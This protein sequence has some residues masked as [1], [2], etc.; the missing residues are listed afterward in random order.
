VVHVEHE[1][2][3]LVIVDLHTFHLHVIEQ[4]PLHMQAKQCWHL[5][6]FAATLSILLALTH[7][8]EVLVTTIK[9]FGFKRVLHSFLQAIVVVLL[10]FILDH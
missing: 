6:E 1:G 8:T 7:L 4:K 2:E 9:Q 10:V 3:R 5:E